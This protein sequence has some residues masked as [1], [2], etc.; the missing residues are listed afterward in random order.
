LIAYL[1]TLLFYGLSPA[2]A[3][4]M[5]LTGG[6]YLSMTWSSAIQYYRGVRSRWKGRVYR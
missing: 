1:P 4:L 3:L 2:W 6:L 5:P